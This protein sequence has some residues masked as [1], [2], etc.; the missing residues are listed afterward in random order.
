M[1]QKG[2]ATPYFI[3]PNLDRYRRQSSPV[4]AVPKPGSVVLESV[5]AEQAAARRCP[6]RSNRLG[7]AASSP[8]A[9]GGSPGAHW[10][11]K[12]PVIGVN[13]RP[14][15]D[16][17]HRL[18]SGPLQ[19]VLSDTRFRSVCLPCRRSWVRIPS[20]AFEK[21]CVGRPFLVAQSD[22]A[23]ASSDTDWTLG[24]GQFPQHSGKA[25]VCRRFRVLRTLERL[26]VFRRSRVGE[27]RM[28]SAGLGLACG[29]GE[30][31]RRRKPAGS[32]WSL[33]RRPT[34]RACAMRRHI[35]VRPRGS[36]PAR[37]RATASW[38]KQT[39]AGLGSQLVI[40]PGR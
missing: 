15:V 24:Q 8:S 6:K 3:W 36:P 17:A 38:P 40:A 39:R 11:P 9:L 30:C 13:S 28:P 37:E 20:A 29:L 33:A 19:A 27:G 12:L 21:V 34:E 14:A 22:G 23:S 5:A 2:W 25:L 1:L 10:V 7:A 18:K 31:C 4:D 26:R 35:A 32:R 16:A